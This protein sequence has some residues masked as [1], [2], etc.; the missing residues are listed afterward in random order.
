DFYLFPKGKL[1]YGGDATPAIPVSRALVGC[2]DAGSMND[3]WRDFEQV[4]G[5]KHVEGRGLYGIRRL[6]VD[7]SDDV[8]EDEDT[9][10]A[11]GGWAKGSG[12]RRKIY[13][14]KERRARTA[15]AAHAR[16]AIRDIMRGDG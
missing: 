3:L 15:K 1:V 7:I 10:D 12:T 13:A 8:T 9:K 16:S 11:L 14:A 5:V 6:S 4:A 2:M